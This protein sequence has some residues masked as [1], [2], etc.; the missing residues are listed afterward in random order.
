MNQG[1]AGPGQKKIFEI[2]LSH[3]LI[4]NLGKM[5]I[6]DD[7]DPVLRKCVMQLYDNALIID[8]SL[9]SPVDMVKRMTEIMEKATK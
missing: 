4:K 1:Q 8:G 6:A 9:E 3:P 7:K 5:V 2:N